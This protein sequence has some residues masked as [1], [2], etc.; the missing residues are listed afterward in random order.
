MQDKIFKNYDEQIEKLENRGLCILNDEERENVKRCLSNVGYYKLINGYKTLFIDLDQQE[1]KFLPGTNINELYSLYFFDKQ[2]RAILLEYI[3]DVETHIKTLIAYTF[4]EKHGHDNYLIYKNFNP[5][6]ETN[7]ITR[8]ISEIQSQ[9]ANRS[10]DPSISHYLSN[11]GYIPLWVL[12]GILTLGT[13]SKFYSLMNE[14]ERV[15]ISKE[16][17]IHDNA[18]ESI[19]FYISSVRNSCAHGN[20]VYCYRSKRPLVSLNYHDALDIPKINNEHIYG[21]R[22]L[23]AAVLALKPLLSPKQFSKMCNKIEKALSILNRRLKVIPTNRVL[24]AMGFP[25]NWKYIKKDI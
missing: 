12:N 24:T 10:K 16:F 22:D 11:Y 5:K 18:L 8:L 9:I 15:E 23:F 14:N 21:K 20:R 1:E 4:S 17:N 6:K 25:D 13:V 7:H 2:L 19:L 3:L